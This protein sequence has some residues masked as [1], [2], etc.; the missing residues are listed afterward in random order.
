M[1]GALCRSDLSSRRCAE[2]SPEA[3]G[4]AAAD[5]SAVLAPGARLGAPAGSAERRVRPDPK[6]S[7]GGTPAV[8]LTLC[9][10]PGVEGA[11]RFT[12]GVGHH[13]SRVI[14]R[15]EDSCGTGCDIS[16]RVALERERSDREIG[17]PQQ[18]QAGEG[19]WRLA[20]AVG[21]SNEHV[22][23]KLRRP[24]D[25]TGVRMSDAQTA[26]RSSAPPAT[27]LALR[28]ANPAPSE[29]RARCPASPRPRS[30]CERGASRRR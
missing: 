13:E 6:R 15:A 26:Q 14:R 17:C 10:G 22:F 28:A 16:Q 3:Q 9:P 18:V 30:S 23:A 29:I 8:A 4:A 25:G 5:A 1:R 27:A 21:R 11:P 12:G 19:A 24:A 2:R 7:R 20:G